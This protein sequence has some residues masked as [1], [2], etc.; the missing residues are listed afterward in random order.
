LDV[1]QALL[2]FL[3]YIVIHSGTALEQKEACLAEHV[4]KMLGYRHAAFTTEQIQAPG[5]G[6]EGDVY[7]S[8]NPPYEETQLQRQPGGIGL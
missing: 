8:L 1:K 2:Q 7:G 5:L 3:L 6:K 4:E